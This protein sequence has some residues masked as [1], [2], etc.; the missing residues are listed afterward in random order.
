MAVTR[1]QLG[2]VDQQR[3]RFDE[4]ERWYEQS[5]AIFRELNNQSQTPRRGL[6]SAWKLTA[7][8]R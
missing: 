5:L 1:F 3:G 8:R 2:V 6:I 7:S 4:A